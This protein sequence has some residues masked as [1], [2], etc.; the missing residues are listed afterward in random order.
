MT[1]DEMLSSL[2]MPDLFAPDVP[3]ED[4]AKR[5]NAYKSY[6]QAAVN[7]FYYSDEGGRKAF[8]APTQAKW[9]EALAQARTHLANGNV[10]DANDTIMNAIKKGWK[11]SSTT[12]SLDWSSMFGGLDTSTGTGTSTNS[13]MNLMNSLFGGQS[14]STFQP[15][16]SAFGWWQPPGQQ[17]QTGNS[18][19]GNYYSPWS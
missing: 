9:D 17:Q 6:L 5:F 14:A 10:A 2:Q 18:W 4:L 12:S 1:I 13:I 16:Q 8:R 7:P 15:T 19:W 11:S 3:N